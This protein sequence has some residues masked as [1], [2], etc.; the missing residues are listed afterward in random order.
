MNI[1]NPIK[2]PLRGSLIISKYTTYNSCF[3]GRHIHPEVRELQ[4]PLQ[5]ASYIQ[6][7]VDLELL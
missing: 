4:Y 1:D 5:Y 2:H 3:Y 7:T 6:T